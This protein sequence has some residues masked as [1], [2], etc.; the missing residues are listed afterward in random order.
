MN[1]QDWTPVIFNK[2]TKPTIKRPALSEDAIRMRKL[3][4]EEYVLPKISIAVQQ[5]IKD[6]RVSKGWTQKDL[7]SRLNVKASVINGYESGSVIPDNKTLQ[8]LSRVL[9]VP[10]KLR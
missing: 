1:H 3:E 5:Q 2:S 10:L 8:Q 7:A 4:D 9:G 6:A